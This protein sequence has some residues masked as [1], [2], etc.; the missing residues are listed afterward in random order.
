VAYIALVTMF[1]AGTFNTLPVGSSPPSFTPNGMSCI[2]ATVG[3]FRTAKGRS[4]TAFITFAID[5][6]P[7]AT[8]IARVFTFLRMLFG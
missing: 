6:N 4:Y 8:T 3:R 1:R 7:I 5:T 2:K